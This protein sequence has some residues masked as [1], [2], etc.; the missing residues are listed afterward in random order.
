MPMPIEQ[1]W[2]DKELQEYWL[3]RGAAFVIDVIIIFIGAWVTSFF[4]RFFI[5]FWFF[6]FFF[7][8]MLL[9]YS[10]LLEG[11][12][13]TTFGKKLLKLYVVSDKGK[14][15]VSKGF[16]RNISKIFWL[17]LALE[18]AASIF[19]DGDPKQRYLDRIVDTSV[20]RT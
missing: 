2:D 9:V 10:A 1:I 14:M 18:I 19:I 20:N 4:I 15:D 12:I 8:G 11:S 5:F 6:S 7:G 17:L 3:R 13:G 16:M